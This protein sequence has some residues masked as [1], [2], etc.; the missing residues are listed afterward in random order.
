VI[1]RGTLLTFSQQQLE[2]CTSHVVRG[3]LQLPLQVSD[4]LDLLA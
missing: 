2:C 3:V 1:R 4:Q